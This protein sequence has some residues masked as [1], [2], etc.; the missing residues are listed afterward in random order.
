MGKLYYFGIGGTGSRVLKSLFMLLSAGVK[1][2]ATEVVP[3]I[4]DP[5]KGAADMAR[6]ADLVREYQQLH[7][8]AKKI[9]ATS[10]KADEDRFFATKVS[11]RKCGLVLP[12]TKQS[13]K[14]F[15]EAVGYNA[16]EK[17]QKA[18]V[19]L[20]FSPEVRKMSM[21]VGFKGNPNMGSI[22]LNQFDGSDEFQDFLNDFQT[23]DRI[24]IAGSIFGGTGAS[25]FPLL[26]KTLRNLD[27][28][29]GNV[30]NKQAI[31]ESA[32]GGSIV[33]PYFAVKKDD[34]SA[35][36]SSTFY[37]K[38]IAALGYYEENLTEL[39]NL[40]YIGDNCTAALE[41]IEGGA[42]QK[43]PAHFIELASALAIYDFMETDDAAWE[44]GEHYYK[45]YALKDEVSDTQ[46]LDFRHLYDNDRLRI[47]PGLT[48]LLLFV[49]YLCDHLSDAEKQPWHIQLG[50]VFQS[51]FKRSSLDK[52]IEMYSTWLA[53]LEGLGNQRSF[54][55]FAL[56]ANPDQPFGVVVGYPEKRG[57]FAKK[58]YALFN[59]KLNSAFKSCK[60][61]TDE[62]KVLEIF[63]A[64]TREIVNEKFKF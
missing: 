4:I 55:P 18:I 38:A 11:L 58:D 22:V 47:A 29:P 57:F 2:N 21:E 24:F 34:D 56:E 3:I 10:D 13:N 20:L 43:N 61:S 7:A 17:E 62:A 5:D 14:R 48:Q 15:E 52:I 9:A 16:M 40:Y 33:L 53:E 1:L 63:Y 50:R 30:A 19:Q 41:N 54:A 12:L 49:N 51:P 23:G 45:E 8:H 27:A 60:G 39:N 6:T 44:G 28:L 25:G 37:S 59:D 32:I 64:A 26:V 46:K 36:D 31:K 42:G 35:I